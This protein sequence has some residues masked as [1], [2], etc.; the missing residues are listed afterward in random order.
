[1]EVAIGGRGAHLLHAHDL[2][3]LDQML[4]EGIDGIQTI[5]LIVDILPAVRR[6]VEQGEK[7]VELLEPLARLVLLICSQYALRLVDDED[8]THLPNHIDR[9]TPAE[10]LQL[11]PDT[12]S[13]CARSVERLRIDDHHMEL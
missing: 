5:D 12:P 9:S 2:D 3:L 10:L 6:T 7:W 1:M 8:G 4:V 13:C 11:H